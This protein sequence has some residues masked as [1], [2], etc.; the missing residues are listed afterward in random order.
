M[1]SLFGI[2]FRTLSAQSFV[3][4][5]RR[6]MFTWNLASPEWCRLPTEQ[7]KHYCQLQE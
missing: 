3:H 7:A 5:L 1:C 2:E 6:L 4:Y